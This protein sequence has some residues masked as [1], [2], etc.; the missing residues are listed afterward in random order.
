M[1]LAKL[2]VETRAFFLVSRLQSLV[3]YSYTSVILDM[4]IESNLEVSLP[5]PLD[6]L[7]D[8]VLLKPLL[9]FDDEGTSFGTKPL[10]AKSDIA[11]DSCSHVSS[12]ST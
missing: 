5:L 6:E 4:L 8:M 1:I 2:K 3:E 10:R 11:K 12:S 7:F 9:P